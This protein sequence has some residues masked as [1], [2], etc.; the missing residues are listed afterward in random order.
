MCL[1]LPDFHSNFF[2]STTEMFTAKGVFSVTYWVA[3]HAC[4]VFLF[5]KSD[6]KTVLIPIVRVKLSDPFAFLTRPF[7][8]RSPLLRRPY[9]LSRDSYQQFSGSGSFCC[10]SI[11]QIRRFRQPKIRSTNPTD[12]FPQA[13]S[14]FAPPSLFA[15]P[16]H[17]PA[18]HGAIRTA[19]RLQ[20]RV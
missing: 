4:T 19:R 20:R 5:T 10:N 3:Y 17:S 1:R 9:H 15:G 11:C 12:P 18:L 13:A 6:I 16:C 2:S 14:P 7:R 8:Q